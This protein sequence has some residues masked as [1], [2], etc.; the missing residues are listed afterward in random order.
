[1]VMIWLKK[2]FWVFVWLV[3]SV[4]IEAK[5]RI[6]EN[7]NVTLFP[8]SL[9]LY[10]QYHE[11]EKGFLDVTQPPY[12]AIG[13]GITDDSKAIQQAINDAF[14]CNLVVFFPS[15]T[16]L[17]SDQLTCIQ[18]AGPDLPNNP[19][20]ESGQRKFGHLL[21]G[22]EK[23]GVWPTIRL[24]DNSVIKDN[25]LIL[26]QYIGTDGKHDP[27]RHYLASI[28]NFNIEMGNN[29]DIS[30]LSNDGAQHCVIQNIRI[31]GNFNTGITALPGSG[32]Y[33][34]NVSIIGGRIG[35]HQKYYRPNPTIFGLY[36]ENQSGNAI[37]IN[38]CRGAVT[39]S[40]FKIVGSHESS[41][42]Y[43]AI[44]LSNNKSGTAELGARANLNLE[45][46]SIETFGENAVITSYKQ[47]V[48]VKNV[49]FKCSFIAECGNYLS[50][51]QTLK[52]DQSKW[53]LLSELVY[54]SGAGGGSV[55]INKQNQRN[56]DND[57]IMK[58]YTSDK[59]PPDD[60]LAR[61]LWNS[62]PS[63]EDEIVDITAYGATRDNNGN[64]DAIAIQQA[65]N[66]ISNPEHADYQKVLFI[67]RG[68]FH[69]KSPIMVKKG[70]KMIGAGKNIS[71]IMIDESWK[72]KAPVSAFTTE[73]NAQ[74]GIV[75][76]DFGLVCYDPIPE[77]IEHKY[78]TLLDFQSGNSIIRDIQT[79]RRLKK[80]QNCVYEAP[81]VKFKGNAG[82][83]FYGMCLDYGTRGTVQ[84]GYRIV[85][86]SDVPESVN[87]Y[88]ISVEDASE[89]VLNEH[90]LLFEINRCNRVSIRGFKYEMQG[91]LLYV[92]D[93]DSL[94]ILGGSGNYGICDSNDHSI[95]RIE[96]TSSV[97]L[98]NLSRSKVSAEVE[99]KF[100]VDDDH[101]SVTDDVPITF[102]SNNTYVSG[103][104]LKQNQ[105][106]AVRLINNPVREEIRLQVFCDQAL[107]RFLVSDL[108]GAS[109]LEGN[110][111]SMGIYD[112]KCNTLK[113]GF[114]FLTIDSK[115]GT[116]TWKIIKI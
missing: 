111:T 107:F 69:I 32:G 63:W 92:S 70:V 27:S 56:Q 77:L 36:L 112:I 29:P 11:W 30:A 21:S 2:I 7:V 75:L 97:Y 79:D 17:V 31:T 90:L 115:I 8:D 52:G 14:A 5:I 72:P 62:L 9:K 23:N 104:I 59:Q 46:G 83:K 85:S 26:F 103:S 100:F 6:Y 58:T 78:F 53:L 105:K 57:F 81:L 74:A 45:D 66:A 33:T 89:V 41:A 109:V 73:N 87:F 37:K 20:G 61:H 84:Q 54:S 60:L 19:T 116:K 18:P 16:F 64:D 114:Y 96:N 44:E 94:E 28:R 50:V 13:D 10:L 49:Y 15:R 12:R 98:A 25:I 48:V 95:F 71:L 42:S 102:Y 51:P 3:I 40:G 43:T 91:E 101:F 80:Y 39:I 35:I 82:G 86:V 55:F 24:K 88:Q 1:M 99:D 47:D 93:T 65:I 4:Q 67:P 113:P 68:H 106:L 76:S 34:A 108:K 22:S 110:F 38:E